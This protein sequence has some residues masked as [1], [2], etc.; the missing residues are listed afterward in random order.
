MEV[1]VEIDSNFN[2]DDS[3]GSGRTC[4]AEHDHNDGDTGAE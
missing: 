4:I 1:A 2:S 3:D